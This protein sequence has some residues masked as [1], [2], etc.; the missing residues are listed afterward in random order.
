MFVFASCSKLNIISSNSKL[1]NFLNIMKIIS[2]TKRK[3]N[4]YIHVYKCYITYILVCSV[5]IYVYEYN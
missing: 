3:K 2:I 1:Y 4:I 5:D